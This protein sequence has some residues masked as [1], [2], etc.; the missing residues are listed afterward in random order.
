MPTM[1][2]Y[3]FGQVAESIKN[4]GFNVFL[5]KLSGSWV[6]LQVLRRLCLRLADWRCMSGI[7]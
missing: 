1:L 3:G 5:L 6:S 7:E 4:Q 2:A